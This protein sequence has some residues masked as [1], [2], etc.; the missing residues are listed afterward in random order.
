MAFAASATPAL[1]TSA[2]RARVR[3]VERFSPF[4]D[5]RS[6]VS[7]PRKGPVRSRL[8]ASRSRIR[9]TSTP[10]HL[11]GAALGQEP[12]SGHTSPPSDPGIRLSP[13]PPVPIKRLACYNPLERQFLRR[14]QRWPSRVNHLVIRHARDNHEPQ[15]LDG[16]Q[17]REGR[18]GGAHTVELEVV[19]Y[20][21]DEVFS[22]HATLLAMRR[23]IASATSCAVSSSFTSKPSPRFASVSTI[24]SAECWASHIAAGRR[25]H[26]ASP[27]MRGGHSTDA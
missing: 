11:D 24:S 14:L 2:A 13:P 15:R 26:S 8:V 25:I 20:G 19:G 23:L 9:T 4:S 3:S 16:C 22:G 17:R 21:L 10:R 27:V 12:S 6:F 7:C 1:T 5:T 18:I